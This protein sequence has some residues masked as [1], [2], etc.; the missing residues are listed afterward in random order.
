MTVVYVA[1]DVGV[2][3]VYLVRIPKKLMAVIA[4]PC[5]VFI[6]AYKTFVYVGCRIFSYGQCLKKTS[7]Y[8]R[9]RRVAICLQQC[10]VVHVQFVKRLVS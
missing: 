2:L 1:M 6:C 8:E 4:W 10:S 5:A 3:H 7:I 9:T